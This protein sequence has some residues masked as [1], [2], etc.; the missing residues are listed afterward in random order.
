MS[1][2]G[3][4]AQTKA[5][6][7]VSGTLKI[8]LAQYRSLEAF[9]MFASD[10]DE[11]TKRDLARG[12]RLTELLKQSQ[13]S[14]MS[15]EKQT[16]SIFAGT[17]GYLDEIPVS[18]VLKFETELHDHIERKTGIFTTIRET[19]KLDDDTSAE[20]ENV[21]CRVHQELR[22]LRFQRIPGRQRRHRH[23]FFRR[24][25]AGKDRSAEA[26]NLI[27]NSERKN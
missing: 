13:F 1:R 24:G 23:R 7:S 16:V 10:L 4:A 18:D 14:P 3:G 22:H 11:T 19:L 2:V 6:K 5:L 8:S 12:A 27:R 25:R 20:L 26:L 17:H 9:A 15:F 21:L